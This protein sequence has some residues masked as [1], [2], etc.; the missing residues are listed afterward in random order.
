LATI[1][2]TVITSKIRRHEYK[3]INIPPPEPSPFSNKVI[4][5]SSYNAKDVY[6]TY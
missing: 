1:Y 4:T 3:F 5:L 6:V 2:L